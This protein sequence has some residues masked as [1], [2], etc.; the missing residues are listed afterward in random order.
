MSNAV[1]RD[2]VN[3]TFCDFEQ[4][5]ETIQFGIKLSKLFSSFYIIYLKF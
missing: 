1:A 5:C 2:F 4:Q 3:Q